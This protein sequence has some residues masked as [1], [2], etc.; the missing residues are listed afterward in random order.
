MNEE[1]ICIKCNKPV[2]KFKDNYEIFE[3]MHWIFFSFGI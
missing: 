3:S 2:I 1:K